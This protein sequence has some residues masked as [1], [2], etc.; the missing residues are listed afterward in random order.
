MTE[1]HT[2][3]DFDE[4]APVL[5]VSQLEVSY[6]T[7][8]YGKVTAVDDVSFAVQDD[9]IFGL[10]GESGC[11]KSTV[12]KAVLNLLP[13]NGAIES[14]A[15]RF[16][17]VDITDLTREEMDALRWE[18]ISVISQGAMNALNPVHRISDQILE[19]IQTH[20]DVS[21]AEARDRI[22]DL[23]ELV[24]LDSQRMDEYPHQYS[25]GMKQRAY[26]AMALALEPDIIIADEPTTALD[27]I[28][29]DQ[30]L[31]QI[32][33]LQSELGV[34]M[35]LIS[36]DISVIA[37]TCERLGVM[38]S[39][40]MMESGNLQS[41][42]AESHNPYTLGL[43]NAFPTLKGEKQD[44]ISI[45]GSPPP[46]TNLPSGCR[47]YDRCP[48][49]EPGCLDAHPPLTEVND[50]HYSACYRHEDAE[51]MREQ[52]RERDTWQ[53]QDPHAESTETNAAAVGEGE[54][55]E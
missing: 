44:L 53:K 37:E 15:V 50:D 48:F 34:S 46:I 30:I 43:Q 21:T 42:F 31:R 29:Q 14:G 52:A 4:S 16:K 12:A 33:E 41:I 49:A 3:L 36:H 35:V 28:V 9:E 6:N 5:E 17:G 24:G 32:K 54:T 11:G 45:P 27:V 1:T 47:F 22:V 55:N 18:H 26:I 19:A 25:G 2:S 20:R 8:E 40:K 10:V 13:R 38:Y 7:R 39:G 23:F 51:M